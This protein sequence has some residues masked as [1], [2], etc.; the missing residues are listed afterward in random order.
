MITCSTLQLNSRFCTL[1]CH[2]NAHGLQTKGLEQAD[3][4]RVEL[5]LASRTNV[6][7]HVF[8]ALCLSIELRTVPTFATAHLQRVRESQVS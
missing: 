5:F 8:H 4:W 7:F 3:K 1:V 2:M 6:K